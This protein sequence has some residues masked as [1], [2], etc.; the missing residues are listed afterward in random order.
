MD[1]VS[2]GPRGP[3]DRVVTMRG[4][5]SCGRFAISSG[6]HGGNGVVGFNARKIALVVLDFGVCIILRFAI[7]I[8]KTIN[9]PVKRIVHG[10]TKRAL[11]KADFDHLF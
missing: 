1:Q 7:D 3:E 10:Q 11:V 5:L 2:V 8:F 6:A 4:L 9:R